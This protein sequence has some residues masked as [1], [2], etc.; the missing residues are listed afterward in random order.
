MCPLLDSEGLCGFIV[1]SPKQADL[2]RD[3]RYSMHSFPRP[4]NEDAFYLT[5]TARLIEDPGVRSRLSE[6][7]VS[8][9]KAHGVPIPS[10][11]DLL[12][13]FAITSCLLTRTTGHGDPHPAHTVWHAPKPS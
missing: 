10:T 4:D 7:F 3:G 12:F 1:P 6:V 11:H 13:G 8:E 5:G 2:L 9:R